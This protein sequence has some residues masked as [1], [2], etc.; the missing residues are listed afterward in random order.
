MH[1]IAAIN[2]HM[3]KFHANLDISLR[4]EFLCSSDVLTSANEKYLA[5]SGCVFLT[6]RK[7]TLP[8][9]L[10][11]EKRHAFS[12]KVTRLDCPQTLYFLCQQKA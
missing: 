10:L 11:E 1:E 3:K 8:F 12:A 5:T 4:M 7:Y 6:E 2:I 9:E